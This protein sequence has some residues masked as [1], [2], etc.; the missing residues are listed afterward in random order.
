M[1]YIQIYLRE[2]LLTLYIRYQE[3][4]III[5]ENIFIIRTLGTSFEL[6]Y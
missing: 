5:F 4:V 1:I 3:K 2:N 6:K